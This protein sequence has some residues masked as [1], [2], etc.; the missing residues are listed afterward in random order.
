MYSQ[1]KEIA[2]EEKSKLYVAGKWNDRKK[3]GT[4]ISSLVKKG[5]TI[6][7]NWTKTEGQH[8][9]TSNPAEVLNHNIMCSSLDVAAVKEAN[10]ILVIMDDPH[11]AYRGTFCEIGV[12]LG[13]DKKIIIYCPDKE[14]SC[15]SNCFYHHPLIDHYTNLDDAI[16]HLE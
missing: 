7:H 10:C 13:L 12:A 14:S 11:Y 9:D 6:T 2:Q 5:F 16:K 15:K 3:I 1:I 8:Y 4:I